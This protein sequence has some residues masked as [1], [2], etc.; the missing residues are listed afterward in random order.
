[1]GSGDSG[2][3]FRGML[4]GG[5]TLRT[6]LPK[7]KDRGKIRGRMTDLAG[8]EERGAGAGGVIFLDGNVERWHIA[9]MLPH[10]H[11]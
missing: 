4:S 8:L 1:M 11:V 5:Y 10:T 7:A 6:V 9:L 3:L 2:E